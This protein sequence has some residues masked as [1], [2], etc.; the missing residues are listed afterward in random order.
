MSDA[1]RFGADP[2]DEDPD[3]KY[4]CKRGHVAGLN[5][6]SEL[7]VRPADWDG[8]DWARTAT[9][10]GTRQGVL[11]PAPMLMVSQRLR[12]LLESER[13][14]GVKLEVAHLE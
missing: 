2:F 11:A 13:V 5:L 9:M 10:I 7:H 1:T 4:R 12:R 6:L 3:G 14:R 8:S